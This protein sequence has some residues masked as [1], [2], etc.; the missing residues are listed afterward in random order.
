M[1]QW[2]SINYEHVIWLNNSIN[3]E[4]FLKFTYICVCAFDRLSFEQNFASSQF[5]CSLNVYCM[6]RNNIVGIYSEQCM[7]N[8]RMSCIR[9]KKTVIQERYTEIRSFFISGILGIHVIITRQILISGEISIRAK[10]FAWLIQNVYLV[11]G[12]LVR[13][14]L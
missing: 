11:W 3:C 4:C 8:M 5:E 10:M 9:V 12:F 6:S 2:I 14:V 1:L 7:C 13:N